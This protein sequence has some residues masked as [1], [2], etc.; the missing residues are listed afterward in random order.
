MVIMKE[1]MQG[2]LLDE[3]VLMSLNDLSHLCHIEPHFII[4]LV[5]Y[6]VLEPRVDQ[7]EELFFSGENIGRIQTILRLTQ[8]LEVNLSGAAV[9]V[10]LLEELDKLRS[11]IHCLERHFNSK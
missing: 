5:E 2:E 8:D 1:L 3:D 6:G 9:I 10:E 4:E 7:R 11:K